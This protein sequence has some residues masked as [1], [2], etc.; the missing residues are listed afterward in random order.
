MFSKNPFVLP[1][2]AAVLL[3]FLF[4]FQ[5][6]QKRKAEILKAAAPARDSS[7][8]VL[9]LHDPIFGTTQG[10]KAKCT[11]GKVYG[12]DYPVAGK[13]GK[14]RV[15]FDLFTYAQ[16]EVQ[17]LPL[18]ALR[19]A[20]VPPCPVQLLENSILGLFMNVKTDSL[21]LM[22]RTPS[23]VFFR[24]VKLT[25]KD[26][27]PFRML[28]EWVADTA[29]LYINGLRTA[30]VAFSGLSDQGDHRLFLGQTQEK[31]MAELRS[32]KLYLVP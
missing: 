16:S 24:A 22:V 4:I 12:L 29:T 3:V 5:Q 10:A 1:I 30:D 13:I 31:K 6:Q 14:G 2:F 26:S 28:V 32:L 8:A 11:D 21:K 23:G 7:V 27:P 19:P 20:S 18:F 15:E 9:T 17:E 25:D